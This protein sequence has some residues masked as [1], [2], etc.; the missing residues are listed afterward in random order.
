MHAKQRSELLI[1]RR[2]S[3]MGIFAPALTLPALLVIRNKNASPCLKS[4]AYNRRAAFGSKSHAST[5]K[6]LLETIRR[7]FKLAMEW[8]TVS[9]LLPSAKLLPRENRRERVGA[10]SPV[11]LLP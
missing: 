6:R 2:L 9:N 3:I 11:P 5:Q 4:L 10:I 7:I 8:T 1:G